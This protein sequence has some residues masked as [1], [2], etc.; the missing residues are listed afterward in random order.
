[1]TTA[2]RCS[3]VRGLAAAVLAILCLTGLVLVPS[4]AAEQSGNASL[5][6]Q[7]V[8]PSDCDLL[9]LRYVSCHGC[10]RTSCVQGAIPFRRTFGAE[11]C[12]LKG[13]PSGYGFVSTI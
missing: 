3:P 2:P 11:A 9:G 12:A 5:Y 1:M 4:A 10:S 13:Q 6:D 8:G 7:R